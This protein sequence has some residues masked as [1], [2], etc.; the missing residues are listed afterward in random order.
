V[1]TN[2]IHREAWLRRLG[3]GLAC[4]LAGFLYEWFRVSLW[5][6]DI[7]AIPVMGLLYLGGF[8]VVAVALLK[9]ERRVVAA[10]AIGAPAFAMLVVNSGHRIAPRTWFLLHRPLFEIARHV[11][12]GGEY[13]GNPLP[14]QLRFL[15]ANGNVSL[16]SAER[17]GDRPEIRFFPQWVGIPDDAGG[18]LYS[19]EGSPAGL[20]LYGRICTAPDDLGDGWWM[21]GL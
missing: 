14:P 1:T 4:W 16:A 10:V 5:L 8:A 15:S 9:R 6:L 21:C 3:V 2:A 18:Y 13:Y 11:E 12:P 17:I 20:D 19:P 7:V